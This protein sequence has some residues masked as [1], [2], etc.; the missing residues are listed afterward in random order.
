[1]AKL[2]WGVWLAVGLLLA[3]SRT[4]PMTARHVEGVATPAALSDHSAQFVQQVVQVTEGVHVA[5]GFGLANVIMI[6]G[7]DGVIIVDTTESI[8]TATAVWA[9]LRE[10]TDKPV[11]AIVY[12]HNHA[13]HIFGAAVFAAAG[14]RP[15]IYAHASTAALVA[16]VAGP[17][18]PVV[19]TRSMRM[20]GNW[21]DAEAQVNA[22]IGPRLALDAESALG[23]LPPT[24][25][26]TDE[27][28]VEA[29]GVTF[30]LVHV[31]G[32]TPD[33]LMVWLP[34]KRVLLCGDDFYWAF[35]NLYTIRGTPFRSLQQWYQ[36]L[37]LMRML[38]AEHLVPSHGR[39][40][41]GAD[42]IAAVLTDYRDA[43]QYI[44]DQS[45]RGMNLGLTPNELVAA[46]VLPPHLAEKPY[47]QP[48]Y[49]K[50]EWGVRAM[51]SGHLGWFDGD[52][53]SLQ[54]LSPGAQA[55]LMARLAGGVEALQAHT[56]SALARGAY[57]EALQLAGCLLQLDPA[58]AIYRD[59]RIQALMGRAGEEVNPNAR[60]WYLTEAVEL[61]DRLVARAP[62]NV[63]EAMVQGYPLQVFF[64]TLAVTLDPRRSATVDRRVG[65]LFPE[66]GEAFSIHVRRGVAEIQ[67]LAPLSF[68]PQ[69]FDIAVTADPAKWK[70]MLAG[71]RSPW[72]TLPAFRYAR[73]NTLQFAR[74]LRMFKP[75]EQKLPALPP[76]REGRPAAHRLGAGQEAVGRHPFPGGRTS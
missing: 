67:A 73:G 34:A 56:Q 1:M 18:R 38:P 24:V 6:E 72:L 55:D 16:R 70:A 35:P 7:P 66:A 9:A 36:S 37:D 39:P 27:L 46:V 25:T 74:F 71:L 20:F 45:I 32:E 75:E 51:F 21:L 4:E 28:A 69:A 68:D 2:F 22:G 50:P 64:D 52:A 76:G 19:G 57:Q 13:D 61:R 29:A 41:S 62:V 58:S 48:L 23:Y 47:L 31:P 40:I 65:I 42:A 3:C 11:K 54:P 10:I 60:H 44:H 63:S 5:V 26:V 8:P 59:L 14:D 33:Q 17:L 30:Q 53:A 43:I 49:G 15:P 12:T